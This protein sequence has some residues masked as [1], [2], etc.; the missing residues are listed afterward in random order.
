MRRPKPLGITAVLFFSAI[1]AHAGSVYVPIADPQVDGLVFTPQIVL[2]N[3]A[4]ASRVFSRWLISENS[5]GTVRS[6]APTAATVPA[7]QTTVLQLAPV[8]GLLEMT[9]VA[10]MLVGASM[11]GTSSSGEATE[12][13]LPIVSSSSLFAAG[14]TAHLQ[15]LQR[16]ATHRSALYLA[17]LGHTAAQCSVSILDTQGGSLLGPV[18]LTLKALALHRFPDALAGVAGAVAEQ[19]RASLRCDR[20]FHAFALVQ[21]SGARP[22][23]T[24]VLPSATGASTLEPPGTAKEL[25]DGSPAAHCHAQ[26]GL[27][28]APAKGVANEKRMQWPVQTGNYSRLRVRLEVYFSGVNAINPGGL[29]QFFW[30]ALNGKNRDLYGFTSLGEGNQRLMLRAGIGLGP[31]DKSKILE[32]VSLVPGSTYLLDYVYDAKQGQSVWSL[33]DK[34]SGALIARLLDVPN[35]NSIR[36][37][38]EGSYFE[39]VLSMDGKNPVEPPSWGWRYS[40]VIFELF[41]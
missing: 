29:H 36:V 31:G 26:S 11:V 15:G 27:V 6:A 40:D 8:A 14:S 28:F 4:S 35:V 32:N 10:D 17:N 25:C 16:D 33:T 5:D 7:G 19:A 22:F 21:S 13:P 37:A 30:L 23:V 38:K 41:P 34:S 9:G 39:F 18:N 12:F 1:A 24:T 20:P 3:Q 2:S